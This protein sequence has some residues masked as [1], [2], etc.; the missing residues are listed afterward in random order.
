M[1]QDWANFLT[2]IEHLKKRKPEHLKSKSA[3]DGSRYLEFLENAEFFFTYPS[4]YNTC[5]E[6]RDQFDRYVIGIEENI[7]LAVKLYFKNYFQNQELNV[8]FI[9]KPHT[10]AQVS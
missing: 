9:S 10:G 2:I 6:L 3:K 5:M 8:N 1:L 7:K 4:F